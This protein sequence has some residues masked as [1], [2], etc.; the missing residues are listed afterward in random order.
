MKTPADVEEDPD[1]AELAD[2][3]SQMEY[4]SDLLCRPS[5]GQYKNYL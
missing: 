4:F 3:A 5:I 2:G 1:D